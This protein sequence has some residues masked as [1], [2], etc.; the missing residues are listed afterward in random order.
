MKAWFCISDI[1]Q[2]EEFK[3]TFQAITAVVAICAA[4]M[5]LPLAA[6]INAGVKILSYI[7]LNESMTLVCIFAAICKVSR[8][9][10]WYG[11]LKLL[12]LLLIISFFLI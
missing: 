9:L 2:M 11:G 10:L 5:M 8:D 3:K 4:I 6:Y 7:L 12:C 1:V